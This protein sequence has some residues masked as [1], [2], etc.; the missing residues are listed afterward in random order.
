MTDIGETAA[1]DDAEPTLRNGGLGFLF[2]LTFLNVLN[3]ID[4]QL[5]ASFANWVVPELGLTNTQFGLLTGLVFIVF[6]SVMGLFMGT[7]VDRMNR[8]RLIAAGLALWSGLT[9]LSGMAR[10]F[11]SLAL[12]RV[13]IGVG[14]S[15]L[16]PAAMSLFGDRFPA[17]WLGVATGIYGLGV[18]IGIASSL[19]IVAYLEPF[20]GWRGCFF[21]LGGI[22]VVLAGAMLFLKETPRVHPRAAAGASNA[23]F[24]EIILA[25][26]SE[27]RRSP[28][29]TMTIAGGTTFSFVLGA[30]G[31][32]QLWFVQERGF[33]RSEIAQATAWYA[34]VGGVLGTL[35]GGYGGDIFMRRTGIG[36]PMF[37]FWI[38]LLLAPVNVAFRVVEAGSPAFWAGVFAIYFQ[39]GCFYGP[40][41]ATIQELAPPRIRGTVVAFAILMVQLFGI[42]VGV[43]IAG[44]V[45]DA[46]QAASVPE[47]YTRTLLAF[48]LISMAAIPMFFYAGRRFHRDRDA[49]LA[50]ED[51]AARLAAT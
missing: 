22:G 17:K 25:L 26:F 28:A 23:S 50:R 41:F 3:F 7:L 34:I 36:R 43:S 13:F 6:Y 31:F 11:V 51:A 29:L 27:L 38:L 42:G 49:L 40:T 10:G 35:A 44:Y 45:I 30:A 1:G 20:L 21:L 32:E 9:A 15:I 19:F 24:R 18:P 33:D 46:L 16:T 48:T 5:L 2:L 14:E 8:T 12:P 4:R 47:P 37:L 39:V